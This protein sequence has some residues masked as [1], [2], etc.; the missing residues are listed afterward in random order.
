M[1]YSA[2]NLVWNL[3]LRPS[4]CKFVLLA[5]A[6][7]AGNE[8]GQCFPSV[9]KISSDTGL[10][11][12]AVMTSIVKLEALGF[13]TVTRLRGAGNKYSI[14]LNT[15]Q[16]SS[17]AI[18]TS[19]SIGTSTE[20][21]TPPV[22][23]TGLDQYR[24]R[25]TNLSLT[26]QEPINKKSAPKPTPKPQSKKRTLPDDFVLTDRHREWAAK[27]DIRNLEGHYEY[28]CDAAGA[29]GYEYADWDRAFQNA[30]RS[31]WAKLNT[32]LSKKSTK[33]AGVYAA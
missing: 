6:M 18:G 22:P 29:K 5:L 19:T 15:L 31:D 17:A 11:R 9:A 28:F 8:D 4:S 32:G 30:M 23:K 10:D 24:F 16:K 13:I 26:Y 33:V 3:D 27:N 7:R 21:G 25:D 1:S 2:Q 12:K 14:N 20:N